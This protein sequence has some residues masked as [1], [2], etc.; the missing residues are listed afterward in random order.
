MLDLRSTYPGRSIN[1]PHYWGNLSHFT[2]KKIE[3]HLTL[4][5]WHLGDEQ[6]TGTK[7]SVPTL[8]ITYVLTLNIVSLIP[9]A[10]SLKNCSIYPTYRWVVIRSIVKMSRLIDKSSKKIRWSCD[11]RSYRRNYKPNQTLSK[12]CSCIYRVVVRSR[13]SCRPWLWNSEQR[14]HLEMFSTIFRACIDTILHSGFR[15]IRHLLRC[16]GRRNVFSF[17]GGGK[18]KK[19]HCNVKKGTNGVHADNY[20]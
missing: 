1:L 8:K 4:N 11:I 17:G 12:M 16:R 3:G 5:Y 15:V 2:K 18:D 20:H 13:H 9:R 19:G 7:I 14:L 6:C 10:Q